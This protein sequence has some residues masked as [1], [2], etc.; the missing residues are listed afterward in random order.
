MPEQWAGPVRPGER[1]GPYTVLAELASG[2]MGRVYLARSPGGRTV[3][4]KTLL[5]SDD[6]GVVP[7]ADRR[8]FAREVA[9]ARR[10]RGVYTASVVDADAEARV[11]WMATEYVPAP[12]LQAL[13]ASQGP[14]PPDGLH[15]VAAGMTEALVSIH[16]AGLVHRDVKPSNVL[17]PEDGPRLIDF[18][19]SQAADLTRTRAAL[20]TIAF[21]APEQARGEPTTP[22][23][24]VFSLGATLFHLATG[25]SPYRDMGQGT[26]MEQLVRATEGDLDLA[27][28]PP[29]LDLLIRPC[30]SLDPAARPEPRELLTRVGAVIA[31]RPG[32]GGAADWLPTGWST[33]IEQHRRRRTEE[34][35][36]AQRRI[37]PD[38]VTEHTPR[39]GAPT[40]V[41]PGAVT[42]SPRTARWAALSLVVL[43]AG[44]GVVYALQGDGDGSGG[45]GSPDPVR[46]DLRL[47]MVEESQEGTCTD[48]LAPPTFHDAEQKVCYRISTR[49]EDRMSVT[50]LKDVEATYDTRL[51]AWVVRM[52]FRDADAKLFTS[53][54]ERAARRQ[55]PQNQIAIVLG[56]RLISAPS[57]AAAVS[58]GVV[59]IS[60]DFTR[61][62]AEALAKELGAP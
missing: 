40:R 46:Q 37:D 21:A 11:P 22:A 5:A 52:T 61:A 45:S 28:L 56:D 15:W 34:A 17:L 1:I 50:Q 48:A 4:V 10:V 23:S 38:A 18:G 9:L 30:L 27:G 47:A 39:R 24:D 6:G 59:D 8:R 43:L 16:D 44:G 41:L 20:G 14:L 13:V 32:A 33:A 7:E 26:A 19:I 2:G 55:A 58:G 54:T 25:R 29:E 31:A 42:R 49:A 53:L 35:D 36:A 60:G 51:P 57:V 3:A 12:S 62:D